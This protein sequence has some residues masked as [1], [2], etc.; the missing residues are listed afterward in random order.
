MK[1]D[2]FLRVYFAKSIEVPDLQIEVKKFLKGGHASYNSI[3]DLIH[4][5]FRAQATGKKLRDVPRNPLSILCRGKPDSNKPNVS[6]D[7]K[8]LPVR[9]FPSN[10]GRLL[11]NHMYI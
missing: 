6:V 2:V 11:P 10:H 1:D 4:E 3:L 8:F 7:D 5:D 9:E